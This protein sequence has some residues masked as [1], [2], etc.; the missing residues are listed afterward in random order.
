MASCFSLNRASSSKGNRSNSSSPRNSYYPQDSASG[1][2]RQSDN[3]EGSRRTISN[4]N[5]EIRDRLHKTFHELKPT[6]IK[7]SDMS[8]VNMSFLHRGSHPGSAPAQFVRRMSSINHHVDHD[9]MHPPQPT[10][11]HGKHKHIHTPTTNL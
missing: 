4:F 6:V 10:G 2:S 8:F 9:A 1:L 3:G 7:T 11:M 5:A